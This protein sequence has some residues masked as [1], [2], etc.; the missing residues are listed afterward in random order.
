MTRIKTTTTI[1]TLVLALALAPFAGAQSAQIPAPPQERPVVIANATI[2]PV[3]GDVLEAPAWVVFEDGKITRMGSGRAPRVVG[4]QRID[5]ADLHVYP[6]LISTDTILGLT[7][8][9]SVDVTQ[10]Y[11]ERGDF[12]PEVRAVVAVNPDSDHFPVTRANGIL[13]GATYP[14]GGLVAGRCSVVRYDGWTWEDMAI[15]AEAGLV[16]NWPRTEPIVAPWMRTSEAEQRKRIRENLEQ[17]DAYFDDAELYYRAKN[18][19]PSLETDLRYEA[20][21]AA[22]EGRK[23]VFIRANSAGQ[24]ESAVA[25]AVG[26]ELNPVIVGGEEADEA[27]PVLARHDV[28]VIIGGTHRLPDQRH[29]AYDSPFTLPKRLHDGGVRFAIST[30][31][32][33]AHERNL[34]HIAATAAAYGLP[35]EEALRAVTQRAAEILGVGDRYGTIERGKSATLILT[36]GDPLEITTD[37][38]VAFVDG[39]SIDLGSRHKRLYAK[40]REKYRQ[41]GLID[42]EE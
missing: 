42:A 40:Y 24:I 21:R 8:V 28:P 33:A 39:R 13:L 14:R 37:T 4:A 31:G 25:W 41:L 6:G 1:V 11:R 15:D 36:T 34:N 27:I 16:I 18:A 29:D 3:S 10:D 12:T 9:G 19:D 32:G 20:M 23:P 5:G 26:R 2:H 7:E 38:L 17:I 22:I 30:G 35:K